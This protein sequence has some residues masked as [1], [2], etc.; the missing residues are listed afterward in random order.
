MNPDWSRSLRDQCPAA[1]VAFHFKQWGQYEP[2]STTDGRQIL[3]FGEYNVETKFG[4]KSVG[5]K[6]AGR[7]LDGREW[8]EFPV[9]ETAQ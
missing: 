3:P 1:G 5:K 2:L 6:E 4:F 9:V 8:N 7:L